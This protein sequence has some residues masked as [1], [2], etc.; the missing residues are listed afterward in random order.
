MAPCLSCSPPTHN[1]IAQEKKARDLSKPWQLIMARFDKETGAALTIQRAYR[2]FAERCRLVN[3][4]P[5]DENPHHWKLQAACQC[6]L[7][8]HALRRHWV[9]FRRQHGWGKEEMYDAK[10]NKIKR[11]QPKPEGRV[12][13]RLVNPTAPQMSGVYMRNKPQVLCVTT[14]PHHVPVCNTEVSGELRMSSTPELKSFC[15]ETPALA[16]KPFL[17]PGGLLWSARSFIDVCIL[18]VCMGHLG[19]YRIWEYDAKRKELQEKEQARLRAIQARHRAKFS[20]VDVHGAILDPVQRRALIT[21]SVQVREKLAG[22]TLKRNQLSY[23][24]YAIAGQSV[25]ELPTTVLLPTGLGRNAFESAQ[26][27]ACLVA[28]CEQNTHYGRWLTAAVSVLGCEC[29]GARMSVQVVAAERVLL[30]GVLAASLSFLLEARLV[31]AACIACGHAHSPVACALTLLPLRHTLLPL[32][33]DHPVCSMRRYRKKL[34]IARK[35]GL[36]APPLPDGADAEI[37]AMYDEVMANLTLKVLTIPEPV[38]VHGAVQGG[39]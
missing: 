38:F 3:Y 5:S 27:A 15:D 39:H 2:A 35:R 19:T 18:A 24:E 14:P 37:I 7:L 26:R 33:C 11:T 17:R 20:G 21:Q 10:G 36:A 25:V 6:M 28:C 8:M 31:P 4:W 29:Q 23:F 34:E 32:L 9:D 16:Q 22:Q 30:S 12:K 1:A 13:A